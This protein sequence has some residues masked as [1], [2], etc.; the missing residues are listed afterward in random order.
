MLFRSPESTRRDTMYWLKRYNLIPEFKPGQEARPL[1]MRADG[2]YR[3][4]SLVKQELLDKI[5]KEGY[6]PT[7]AFDDRPRVIEMW[8]KNG[9]FVFD[10]NNGRGDF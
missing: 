8:R 5:K 7:V 6:N 2:D 1:Y 4:D 9:I 10:V 3:P